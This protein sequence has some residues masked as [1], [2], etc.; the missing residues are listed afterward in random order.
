MTIIKHLSLSVVKKK[1][2][3]EKTC[4]RI[5]ITLDN[6]IDLKNFINLKESGLTLLNEFLQ[7]FMNCK[8]RMQQLP[9]EKFEKHFGLDIHTN[10]NRNC[11]KIDEN[12]MAVIIKVFGKAK[13]SV[14]AALPI[15][16]E[17]EN[18][19]NFG[20]YFFEDL[21]KVISK[22]MTEC[23]MNSFYS[24]TKVFGDQLARE[25]I[26]VCLSTKHY[27]NSR[28]L[29]LIEL[30]EKLSTTTFEGQ[31]FT[32]GLILSRSLYEYNGKNGKDRRGKLYRLTNSY[33]LI[34]KPFADK[35]FWYLMDGKGSFY[36]S[37]QT[38]VIKNTFIRNESNATLNYFF[39]SY[40]LENTLYG[41]DIAFRVIGPNEVSIITNKGFEFIKIENRWRVRNFECLSKY[42]NSK[43]DMEE[44]VLKAIVYY[45]TICSKNH[46]SSIIWI[47]EDE[48]DKAIN[49]MVSL[50]NKIWKSNLELT[51]E[52]NSSIIQQ[53]LSSDGVTI[54]SKSG[55]IIYCGA[56]VKLDVEKRAGLMGTGESA[57]KMLSY[58]GL[59][60][61]ISQDGN[62]K[63][64][65]ESSPASLVY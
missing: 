53:I 51:D 9:I 33:D 47:P 63:I 20:N 42:L 11:Y 24:G 54:V 31:Y 10:I 6:I 26:S 46:C 59:A 13:G 44:D 48:R 16:L 41:A 43:L 15:V 32:T 27:D 14:I 29:F 28:I 3:I 1:R 5:K 18:I 25:I 23:Y 8:V 4:G 56:I 30:F 50:K 58:N 34:K 57:A 22:K 7:S 65:T 21:S 55:K 39:D 2:Y 37:D 64:F 38:L 40:F 19:S 35:R 12:K 45:A 36:I 49:S 62:I 52:K 61:K 17:G 60:L